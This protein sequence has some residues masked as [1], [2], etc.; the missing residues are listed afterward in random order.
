MLELREFEYKYL[1]PYSPFFM[2]I[3][4]LFSQWKKHVKEG[5]HGHRALNENDLM[6]RINDFQLDEEKALAY[7]ALIV[8]LQYVLPVTSPVSL[9]IQTSF[10]THSVQYIQY[11]LSVHLSLL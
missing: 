8:T 7:F 4:C 6:D 11:T 2:G 1:P 10:T 5:L 3:E 9:L